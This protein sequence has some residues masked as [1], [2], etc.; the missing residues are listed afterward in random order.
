M[1]I[2]SNDKTVDQLLKANVFVIPRFQRAYS[3]EQDQIIQFWQD[4]N[5]SLGET[6]FIGSMVVYDL[7]R[8]SV[9]VVDGQQRLTT[10]TI[11]LCAI[12]E[13][14]KKLGR[15]DLADGL[16][17]YIEQRNRENRTEYVLQTESSFPFLQEEVLKNSPSEAIYEVGHEEV[18]IQRAYNLFKE[19]IAEELQPILDNK[20]QSKDDNLHDSVA[21]LSKIRDTVFDLSVIVVSLDNEDD[22]YLIF[23][24]LNTRG[25]DLALSDL[26]RNHFTKFIKPTGGVDN[27]KLKWTKVLD[28]IDSSTVRL[29]AD[30]FIVHSW[31]SRYDFVTKA[32]IFQ[33]AKQRIDKKNAKSHLDRFVSDAGHWRSIFD[34]DFEWTK[35]EKEVARSL[36][37]LSTFK[38][39]QPTPGILS[40]IRAYRDGVIKYKV[41][42]NAIDAIEKFHFAFNAVTS[43]RSSG[44]ISGMYSLLGRGVFDAKDG[45]EASQHIQSLI[46]KLREREPPESEFHAGFEQIVYTKLHSSQKSLVQYILKKVALFEK[47][48]FIGETDDLTIEHLISQSKRKVGVS[49]KTIGQVGNLILVDAETNGKLETNDFKIKKQILQD[50]GYKLPQLFLDADE[51]NDDLIAENTKRIS[52]LARERIWK[53]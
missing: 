25:K 40:L 1:K 3:W 28:V 30:T 12:R 7:D 35:S 42:R 20:E 23:E 33:K 47:Q 41:L 43:S 52:D 45:Q 38:V 5:D 8:S 18:A 36:G 15:S 19:K 16:Q 13:A 6:Y 37:A 34:T 17:A 10:I 46:K 14:Y 48:P 21:M 32:K 26:L 53:V 44:G 51:L 22:A 39:V 49:E 50:R 27:A 31:Q 24:T 2:E 9:A 4:I 29:N 11:L